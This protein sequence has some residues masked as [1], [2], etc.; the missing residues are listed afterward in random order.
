[1]PT[2]LPISVALVLAVALAAAAPRDTWAG[3]PAADNSLVASDCLSMKERS[4]ADAHLYNAC[5]YD[6]EYVYC[7]VD[8]PSN[9]CA[10]GRFGYQGIDAH[11]QSPS[12]FA[13]GYTYRYGACRIDSNAG[14]SIESVRFDGDRL[15][16]DCVRM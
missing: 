1:V 16:F 11:G 4:N 13:S 12:P 15:V 5:P 10:H 2:S 6:V 3:D 9:K 8:G 7:T 14:V